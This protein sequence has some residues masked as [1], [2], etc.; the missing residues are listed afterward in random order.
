M[1]AME[2]KVKLID[3]SHDSVREEEIGLTG[4]HLVICEAN[5]LYI[6]KHQ[7]LKFY[8]LAADRIS[9]FSRGVTAMSFLWVLELGPARSSTALIKSL[10]LFLPLLKRN[11]FLQR[12]N[13]GKYNTFDHLNLLIL[14]KG[15]ISQQWR[16]TPPSQIRAYIRGNPRAPLAKTLEN[17]VPQL[18]KCMS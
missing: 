5:Y 3:R 16:L 10:W 17:R 11:L 13:L 18:R 4:A 14:H 1:V 8:Q 9:F 12:L 15:H 6:L 7:A 2:A